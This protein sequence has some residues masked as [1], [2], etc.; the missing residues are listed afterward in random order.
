[1]TPLNFLRHHLNSPYPS[2]QKYSTT[3]SI[4]FPQ[5][6]PPTPSK[7]SRSPIPHLQPTS[8]PPGT[9][10]NHPPILQQH[11]PSSPRSPRSLPRLQRLHFS[12]NRPHRARN[13]L[14]NRQRSARIPFRRYHCRGRYQASTSRIRGCE[15][16]EISVSL[17]STPENGFHPSYS[18][19]LFCYSPT[20]S[21]PFSSFPTDPPPPSSP[22]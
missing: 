1:V 15:V 19:I 8:P 3:S 5:G 21:N 22:S 7:T 17:K 6:L 13:T 14:L 2:P 4:L 9:Q 10:A 20:P 16:G 11:N 12:N 18:I